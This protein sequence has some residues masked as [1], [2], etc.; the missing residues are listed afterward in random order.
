MNL[1]Q[2]INL[3]F[4]KS[5]LKKLLLLFVGILIM[6]L[7]EVI[8]V[9][10][11][12]PFIAVVV[13]PEMV[14]ENIYL[15]KV[16]N[17]F[18]FQ[19]INKFIV[20]LGVLLISTLLISNSFQAFMTWR[21]TYFTNM[22]GS[23]LS[24]RLL[25]SYLMR[26]Y[27]FFLLRSS[28]D[29]GKNILTEVS[30]VTSGVIMQSLQI[31]SKIIIVLFLFG[32]LVFVN[33]IIAISA[34]LLLGG[35]Y[36]FIYSLAKLKLRNIGLS[37]SNNNFAL[38]KAT[39]EALSGIKDIKLHGSE[40]MFVNRFLF[41]AVNLANYHAQK[42]L[43]ASL[44]RYL[45]EVVAFGGVVAIIIS[46]IA[47]N[48]G[49]NSAIIPIISLYVMTGYRLMPAFQ[50]IY[51]GIS[52]LKFNI[53]A[54]EILIREFSNSN[55]E[56]RGQVN[57]SVLPFREKLQMNQLD[58]TYE[59]SEVP[60]LKKLDLII[61]P[62]TIVGLVGLTGSGKTTLIDLILGLLTPESGVIS[63]DGT[64]VNNQ[65]KL[66]WQKNIG[67]VPQSIYLTDDTIMANIAFAVPDD[68][69]SIERV[70]KSAKMANL[71]EFITTLPEKYQTFV[72]ER[73]VRLSGGQR[74]RVG[75][76]RALFHDPKVL[77]LDEATNA[78]DNIT[79]NLI[80]DSIHNLS[81]KKT[82]I[83]IAHRLSTVKECDVIHLMN[84]GK[85]IASGSYQE[86]IENNEEFK[87]MAENV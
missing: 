14:Y 65:N 10:T 2:K 61:Y 30:R 53:P 49:M 25:E 83:M 31:V 78:L 62:N 34:A 36:A 81:H 42:V 41:P 15:S 7:L 12:V 79:E 87:R 39:N 73:G 16:Y 86:L 71:H 66:A 50:Q 22:Q 6:G 13:S 54:F 47:I 20:F 59:G 8:G 46:L 45:L 4:T 32:L 75:I 68:E 21:I 11:I 63:L 70:I 43:I 33:P 40:K 24:V 82:I 57:Q 48:N 9:T 1:R 29:L 56:K 80:M 37:A 19:S 44:P 58:F 18:N 76:A 26:P 84:N 85:I 55:I 28:S 38:F 74:Q 23:R 67:Y 27:G 3:I 51:S 72:G 5:E 60:I 64:E 52:N 69:I 77:V 35:L 17:F